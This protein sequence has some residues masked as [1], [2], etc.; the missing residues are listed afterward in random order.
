[1]SAAPDDQVDVDL[2]SLP[3]TSYV[4]LGLLSTTDEFTVAEVQNRA[5][6][7]IRYF[8]GTPALSHIRRDLNKLEEL[9]CVT[10][11]E[12]RQGRVKQ[13]L[14]YRVTELGESALRQWAESGPFE[15]TVVKNSVLM[16]LWLG[17]R[18]G[19][20]DKVLMYLEDHIAQVESELVQLTALIGSTVGVPGVHDRRTGVE[21]SLTVI[22]HAQRIYEYNLESLRDLHKELRAL[23]NR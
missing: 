20:K 21:W 18:A 3:L 11:R 6:R 9:G 15:P 19:N 2:G 1:M 7:F 13:T 22:Q 17:R 16:R 5:H 4:I 14:K 10:A 23:N 12:V 8:Y